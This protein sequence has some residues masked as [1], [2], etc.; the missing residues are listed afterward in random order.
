MS[1][2]LDTL[3]GGITGIAAPLGA[4][5]VIFIFAVLIAAGSLAVFRLTSNQ[6]GIRR[7]KAKI[8][9]GML[10]MLIFRH[11]LR[12]MLLS[13]GGSLLASITNL[14]FLV[15]PMLV[16]IVPLG[17]L[18]V[19]LDLR[20]GFRPLRPGETAV[21]RVHLKEEAGLDDV[22]L[23][24]PDGVTV[25]SP[26][27][28]V[29]DPDRGLREVDFRIRVDAIGDHRIEVRAGDQVVEKR[30]SA[31]RALSLLSPVKPGSG[32]L[33]GI[34]AP[35]EGALPAESPIAMIELSYESISYDFLGIEWA[36]W[37]LLIVF[38]IPALFV[39]RRPFGVDF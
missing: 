9:A 8:K 4:V 2:V 6:E 38:M 15:L 39:L 14:R 19:H 23:T 11:D 29:V 30:V 37:V 17:L 10:G 3:V 24:A 33:D 28:R 13:M 18:F 26:G 7:G 36:W 25:A 31:E 22:A 5:F 16:M 1:K 27:V 20:L 32:F 21:L 34:F 12:R 35:G